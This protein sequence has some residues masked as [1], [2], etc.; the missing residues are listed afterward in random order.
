MITTNKITVTT[1]TSIMALLVRLLAQNS[2]DKQFRDNQRASVIF[3]F[4]AKFTISGQF[5]SADVQ[6]PSAPQVHD[7]DCL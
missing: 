5:D 2:V 1:N 4:V 7:P 3:F 6:S